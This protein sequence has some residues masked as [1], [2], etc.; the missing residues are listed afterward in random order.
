MTKWIRGSFEGEVNFQETDCLS[1]GV[2]LLSTKNVNVLLKYMKN[3]WP[4]FALQLHYWERGQIPTL[5]F[6]VFFIST[7]TYA[8]DIMNDTLSQLSGITL[9]VG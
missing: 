3:P 5:L 6:Y 1:N 2:Q 4:E 8:S 7:Q 9:S